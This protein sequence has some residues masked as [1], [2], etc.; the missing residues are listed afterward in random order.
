MQKIYHERI[1]SR[2]I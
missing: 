2:K 1:K